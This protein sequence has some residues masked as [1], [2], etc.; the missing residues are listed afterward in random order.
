MTLNSW[1]FRNDLRHETDPQN[2][3][4]NILPDYYT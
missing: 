3:G 4:N 2:S 1:E